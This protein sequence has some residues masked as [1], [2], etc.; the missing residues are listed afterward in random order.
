MLI[1]KDPHPGSVLAHA[2]GASKTGSEPLL[3]ESPRSTD[4][5]AMHS[6]LGTVSADADPNELGATGSSAEL[7]GLAVA[8][9]EGVNELSF[10]VIQEVSDVGISC[11]LRAAPLDNLT[12]SRR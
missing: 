9:A 1:P 4:R 12:R 7:V 3:H 5:A 11:S 8:E 10:N 2:A 6:D